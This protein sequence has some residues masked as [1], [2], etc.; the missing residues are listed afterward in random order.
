MTL[1]EII[2]VGAM[3]VGLS[4]LGYILY[5]WLQGYALKRKRDELKKHIDDT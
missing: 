1:V 3:V 5:V 2:A 4:V